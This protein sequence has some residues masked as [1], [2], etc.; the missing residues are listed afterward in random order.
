MLRCLVCMLLKFWDF[1]QG[2]HGSE[3]PWN[4]LCAI[5]TVVYTCIFASTLSFPGLS[6]EEVLLSL[7]CV[8]WDALAHYLKHGFSNVYFKTTQVSDLQT[9]GSSTNCGCNLNPINIYLFK[10]NN[11]NTRRRC[12][13]C[14]KLTIKTPER[15][16]WRRFGVLLLIL[17]KFHTFF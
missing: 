13:I 3:I 8:R 6:K 9:Y 16:P 10:F 7:H 1:Y 17:N 14:S 4:E 15:R 11:R 5:G 12:D 2:C